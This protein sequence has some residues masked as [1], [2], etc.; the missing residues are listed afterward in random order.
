MTVGLPGV[1]IGGI[2][3]LVSALTMPVRELARTLRRE[4]TFAR[5]R[6]VLRHWMLAIGILVAL[7]AT[8]RVLGLLIERVSPHVASS[9]MPLGGHARN[10]LQV[11]ALVL[12][13]GTLAL[14]W[15]A[16][17]LM[18]L[19]MRMRGGVPRQELQP[20]AA[21]GA[22]PGAHRSLGHEQFGTGTSGRRLDSGKYQRVH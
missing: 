2:F 1:G 5:W 9:G 7:W 22:S 10:V 15:I 11:S 21:R 6:F 18:H 8:G 17:N 12:S 13:L 20:M 4:S 19:L 3:Y 14:V 16:V